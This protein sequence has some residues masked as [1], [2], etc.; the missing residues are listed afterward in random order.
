MQ[1]PE[2]CFQAITLIT[3]RPVLQERKGLSC[4][5]I[6]KRG[7]PM[8][9]HLGYDRA[10]RIW[11]LVLGLAIVSILT[12]PAY[13]QS[14]TQP[15]GVPPSVTSFGFGGHPDFGG[16]PPS[17][18]S[19]GQRSPAPRFPAPV[20]PTPTHP[21]RGPIT[22]GPPGRVPGGNTGHHHGH[23]EVIVY[24]YYVPYYVPVADPY[25]YGGPD[26]MEGA[27]AAAYDQE[28]QDQYAGGPTIFDRRGSGVSAPNDYAP[29][30]AKSNVPKPDL[31]KLDPPGDP[32]PD[33]VV[34]AAPPQPEVPVANQPATVLIFKDGHRQE[35]GNY[36]IV[37]RSLFDLSPGRRQKIAL[38]DLDLPA[39]QKANEDLGI[40]FKLPELPTGN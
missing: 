40:D 6:K 14:T 31:R 37:G 17:V 23:N 4:H 24:P 12:I 20:R 22:F 33:P 18:T 27:A 5:L 11:A 29:Q 36:A 13:A 10:M 1:H 30:A 8:Q 28:D 38:D 32:A 9:V 2:R 21:P 7:I 26:V 34:A 39:T 16:V 19:L 35:V 15:N 3:H 25:A